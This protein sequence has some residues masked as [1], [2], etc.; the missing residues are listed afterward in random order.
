CLNCAA[1]FIAIT[2]VGVGAKAMD[3][4]V[5]DTTGTCAVR[6]FTCLGANNP[7]IEMNGGA[8]VINDLDDGAADGSTTFEVTCNADGTAWENAGVA[9]TQLEC[10]VVCTTCA[11]NL[12]TITTAGIGAKPMDGDVTDT[13]GACTNGATVVMDP[14]DG[15]TDGMTNL[16][17]TCNADG[18]AWES[19]GVAV[20]QVECAIP[21]TACAANLITITTAGIGAK[22]MDGD[23]TDTNG[24]CAVRTF[25][26]LGTS[27]NIAVSFIVLVEERSDGMTNLAL[28]CNADGTAWESNGV[29]VTQVECAIPCTACAANLIT[30][31][32]AGIGAK[33]MDG[34][35][36]DTNGACAVRT[37][38]CLGTSSNIAVSFIVLVEER[39]DGMTN[40]ALTCNADGTAWESN[41]VAVTQVECAIPCTACS[42]NLI[43]ITTA[44]IGAKP[45]DGDVT[46]VNGACAVRTFTCL[47][48]TNPNVNNGARVVVDGDD[49]A[50]DGST[51][52]AVTCNADGTA[53]ESNGVAVTQ[54]ECVIPCQRCAANLITL[55]VL[56]MGAHPM[57]GDVTDTTGTCA[58]RTFTCLGASNPNIEINA[59][60]GMVGDRDD[61]AVDGS[62]TFAVTCNA[63]GTAWE[64][65]G[66]PITQLECAADIPC[67]ICAAN[68]IAVVNVKPGSKPMDGDMTDTT[69]ACAVR[70]FTCL[71]TVTPTIEVNNGATVIGDADDGAADGTTTFAVTCN[72]AGTA[73]ESNGVAVTQVECRSLC[74][75]CPA[76]LVT[77]ANVKPGSKPMD[78][79]MT[80]TAG[81]CSARTFTCLGA[82]NPTIEIN[83]GLGVIGDGNDGVLDGSATFSV[84][85]N[86]DGTAWEAFGIP[87]TQLECL[88]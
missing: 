53:W 79:D 67:Q 48:A 32:T 19:N 9:I 42:A 35:V 71:G 75:T 8:G 26:C 64:S 69:G 65:A 54:V 25:T 55:T 84:T 15:G 10:A 87:I 68:L 13:N 77:V 31:T 83:A 46:A 66:I 74:Q 6:T 14:D 23:V 61:G 37:F 45:M 4:D 22:P 27:S 41:G 1:N 34:D 7:N 30:I 3:G 47:G 88:A 80:A 58:V 73:W 39:S 20:T 24:A 59:G 86:A 50:A 76:N 33:P 21:C 18:T 70:T 57:D 78:G 17:L 72:A 2:T 28:T 43:T 62:T 11:A 49:G 56:G 63:D 82:T 40:L 12:I 81:G 16:A 36:T 60:G 38:T 29:A 85:C 51:M 44:G 5:T 52:V